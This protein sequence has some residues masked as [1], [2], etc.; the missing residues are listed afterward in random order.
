MRPRPIGRRDIVAVAVKRTEG[1]I[2]IITARAGFGPDE[3]SAVGLQLMPPG[4]GRV[5]PR[6][7]T[8]QRNGQRSG[9]EAGGVHLARGPWVVEGREYKVRDRYAIDIV[10]IDSDGIAHFDQVVDLLTARVRIEVSGLDE[11][12]PFRVDQHLHQFMAERYA[13]LVVVDRLSSQLSLGVGMYT[14]SSS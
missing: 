12:G 6:D 11:A 7:V 13:Q 9:Q 1:G 3:D 8:A 2:A 14:R 5:E 10:A 4:V